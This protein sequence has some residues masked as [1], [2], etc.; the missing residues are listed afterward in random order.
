MEA[1]KIPK[2]QFMS[3][4]SMS[5]LLP[6]CQCVIYPKLKSSLENTQWIL[7]FFLWIPQEVFVIQD[8]LQ[9]IIVTYSNFKHLYSI[10]LEY[11]FLHECEYVP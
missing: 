4:S 10:I 2:V 7:R 8:N 11:I 1:A 6:I 3:V 9:D 5:K